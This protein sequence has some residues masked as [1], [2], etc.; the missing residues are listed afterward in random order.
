M[1][2]NILN[3]QNIKGIPNWILIG[4]GIA[5]VLWLTDSFPSLHSSCPSGYHRVTST[6]SGKKTTVCL[7]N[8]LNKLAPA[9]SSSSPPP[10]EENLTPLQRYGRDFLGAMG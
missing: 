5:V 10:L 6:L 4:G 8:S 1:N 9:S 7:P 3:K 2:L